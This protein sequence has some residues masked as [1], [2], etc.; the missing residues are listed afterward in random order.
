LDLAFRLRDPAEIP[1]ETWQ[2]HRSLLEQ[3]HPDWTFLD[4]GDCSSVRALA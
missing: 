3:D 2:Q 4:P 1:V